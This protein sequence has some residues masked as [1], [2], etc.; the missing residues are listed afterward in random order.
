[1]NKPSVVSI[2]PTNITLAW[3]ALDN[4]TEFAKQG[5]DIITYYTI[6]VD[7]LGSGTYT[8]LNPTGSLVT[9]K[10]HSQAAVF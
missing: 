1:M 7:T 4:S 9:I 8:S 3:V 6:E 10:M 2:N 5:Y